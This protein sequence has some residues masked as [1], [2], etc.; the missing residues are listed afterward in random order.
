MLDVLASQRP[1]DLWL[2]VFTGASLLL[3][4]RLDLEEQRERWVRRRI[5]GGQVVGGLFL[6]GGAAIV[7]LM[8]LGALV[9]ASV[10]SSSSMVAAFPQL[11]TFVADLAAQ[12]Q[13]P[14]RQGPATGAREQRGLP[15]ATADRLDLVHG[16]PAG[17]RGGAARP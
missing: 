12:V 5:V 16:H 11:D 2:V 1:Q 4:L 10:A 8:L 13:E 14:G 15:G 9:L 17:L 7:A 6:R 3:I